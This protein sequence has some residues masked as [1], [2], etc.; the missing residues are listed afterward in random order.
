MWRGM[1]SVNKFMT[2]RKIRNSQGLSSKLLR[3]Y[4]NQP[5]ARQETMALLLLIIHRLAL[6]HP[7]LLL[8]YLVQETV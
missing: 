8:V 1:C 6:R 2:T 3:A 7:V 5:Y 4:C